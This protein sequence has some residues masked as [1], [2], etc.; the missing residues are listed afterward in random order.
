M[1]VHSYTTELLP[2]CYLVDLFRR[3]D[4]RGSFSKV[5]SCGAKSLEGF[6]VGEFF[7]TW[8]IKNVVRGMHLQVGSA[9]TDKIVTC[10]VGSV[11]DVVVDLREGR[12]FGRTAS[13]GLSQAESRAVII[14]K[15][16]A[17]GFLS[18]SDEVLVA[19]LTSIPYMPEFDAGVHWRSI[20]F[21]WPVQAPI[22]SPRDESLPPLDQFPP[23]KLPPTTE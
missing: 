23:V 15:G 21:D 14:P 20:A 5:F 22:T 13:V 18:T 8:S 11:I 4:H 12:G 16:V 19:Y 10:L 2:G 3:F 7:Y 6:A 17:H 1:K 9:L